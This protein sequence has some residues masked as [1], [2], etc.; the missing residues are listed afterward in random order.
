M[1]HEQLKEKPYA[2]QVI[3]EISNSGVLELDRIVNWNNHKLQ[4]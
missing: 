1:K 3:L 4:F 2:F